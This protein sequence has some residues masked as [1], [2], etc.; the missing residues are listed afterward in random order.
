ME[1]LKWCR[2]VRIVDDDLFANPLMS[3]TNRLASEQSFESRN[4]ESSSNASSNGKRKKKEPT[5]LLGQGK[6]E[7]G[8]GRN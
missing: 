8:Q 2:A 4:D 6:Q 1:E 3:K 5:R 7:A